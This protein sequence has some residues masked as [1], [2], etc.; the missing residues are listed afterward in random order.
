MSA[1]TTDLGKPTKLDRGGV[2]IN[3]KKVGPIQVGI[4][5]ETIKDCMTM[6]FF[7]SV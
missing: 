1:Q 3:T 2:I 6:V 7:S 4:P 5:P